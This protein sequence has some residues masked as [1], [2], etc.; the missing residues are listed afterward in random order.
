[1]LRAVCQLKQRNGLIAQSKYVSGQQTQIS[2]LT[3]AA[4]NSLS[5]FFIGIVLH[6]HNTHYYSMKLHING[7]ELLPSAATM[8]Q[9]ISPNYCCWLRPGSN[10]L[11]YST[12][13][14]GPGLATS[15]LVLKKVRKHRE[16]LDVRDTDRPQ[17]CL[18]T[19]GASWMGTLFPFLSGVTKI[20]CKVE[21]K[22]LNSRLLDG[23][24]V[25]GYVKKVLVLSI[26]KRVVEKSAV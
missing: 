13:T 17:A 18:D 2:F 12:T 3:F 14:T 4:H 20:F 25:I 21:S 9:D 23:G 15:S 1:M 16:A 26:Y 22:F 10:M 19:G 6:S 11:I 7:E 24:F 5:L 8:F